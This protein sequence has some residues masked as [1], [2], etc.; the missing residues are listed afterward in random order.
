[1]YRTSA[2]APAN[3]ESDHFFR[4]LAKS[5]SSQISSWICQIWQMSV[6][7]QYVELMTDKTN[8]ADLT[9]CAFA[10]SVG[11]TRMMKIQNPLVFHKFCQ[12]LADSDV[13]KEALNCTASL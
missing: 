13:T 10:I 12:K 8:A 4:N 6:E 9:G 5:G 7:L 2:P 1:M 11:V 3:P